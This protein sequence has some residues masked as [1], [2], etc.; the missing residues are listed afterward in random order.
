MSSVEDDIAELKLMFNTPG[1]SVLIKSIE[2]E[3]EVLKNHVFSIEDNNK[4]QYCRGKAE[5]LQSIINYQ[6]KV[7]LLEE[8]LEAEVEDA[9][10]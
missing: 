5:V 8:K 9:D 4:F 2:E 6:N 1:W 10:F 7:Q 3:L